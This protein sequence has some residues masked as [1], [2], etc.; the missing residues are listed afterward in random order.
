MTTDPK[1]PPPFRRGMP[2]VLQI[3]IVA[4]CSIFLLIGIGILD[5]SLRFARWGVPTSGE[6]VSIRIEIDSRK[7]NDGFTRDYETHWPTLRYTDTEGTVRE[8]EVEVAIGLGDQS[9]GTTHQ[10]RYLAAQPDRIMLA[11]GFF[12]LWGAPIGF[13]LIG[14]LF[15]FGTMAFF[16]HTNRSERRAYR[17]RWGVDP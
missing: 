17:R 15:T 10:I 14:S 5:E 6:V 12:D 13:I 2:L 3:I 4:F 16:W 11:R 9:V 1:T 8:N 7:D